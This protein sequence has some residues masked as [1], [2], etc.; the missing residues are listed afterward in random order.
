MNNTQRYA[1]HTDFSEFFCEYT[2][3]VYRWALF[4]GL[5]SSNAEEITQDVF[6]TVLKK[7]AFP[8]KEPMLS[9]YLF[10]ITRRHVANF[11]RSSWVRRVFCSRDASF[12]D[13]L[14]NDSSGEPGCDEG[15]GEELDMRG[16]L[17]TL[18][19]KWVEVLLLH[20][21]EGHSRSEIAKILKIAE[22]TV[23]SR[24]RY[25]RAAFIEKWTMK[26]HG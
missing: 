15:E 2:E 26:H 24:L 4:L 12:E 22:G 25:A 9:A 6:V 18:P 1:E 20:D 19:L 8:R 14:A 13:S 7:E 5:D 10:Q 11:R 21:L 3:R 17:A 16:I 23:A